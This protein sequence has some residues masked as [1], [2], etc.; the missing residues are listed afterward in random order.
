MNFAFNDE[1]Q[2]LRDS[3]HAFLKDACSPE[4]TRSVMQTALGYDHALWHRI[5]AE[6]GWAAITIPEEHGGLDLSQIELVAL[7]EEMGSALLC[8]PFFATVCLAAPAIS[9]GASA[10][11]KQELLPHIADGTRTA[12]LAL[13]EDSGR[14]DADAIE[15]IARCDGGDYVIDGIKDY[16]I[17]GQSA[18]ILLVAAR[19]PRSTGEAGIGLFAVSSDSIGVQR[20]ALP[21]MDQTRRQARIELREVRVPGSARLGDEGRAWPLVRETLDLAAVALAAEQVGGAQ[22]CLDMSVDYAKER[23]QFGRPIASFQAVKHKC[24]EMLLRVESSRSAAYYA[25]WAAAA[26]EPELPVLA[27]LA[28]AYCSEA[29]FHCAAESIQIHGGVG[30]TWEY[31]C[32]LHFK[33]ARAGEWLLGTPA[34]HRER[35]ASTIGL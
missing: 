9:A 25:G 27:S 7:M 8:S 18:D 24:A 1:Q 3:A 20:S 5:A 12:T 13:T 10:E 4:V 11:A 19:E 35:V 30:F 33:R 29:Y 22:R 23:I 21:T 31:D 6:L 14:W 34:Y 28:K 26:G 2:A 16:V 32:H 17:D 15:T